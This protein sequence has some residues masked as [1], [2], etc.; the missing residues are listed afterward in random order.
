[1][2]V[3]R[4]ALLALSACSGA[5]A[6]ATPAAEPS[7]TEPSVAV[8]TEASASSPAP[9]T[10][11]TDL[12]PKATSD[13]ARE[14]AAVQTVQLEPVD[15]ALL[16]QLVI[17][18]ARAYRAGRRPLVE[19]HAGWCHIC[20]RVDAALAQPRA[21]AVLEDVVLIRVDT[22]V[23]ADELRAA[24]LRSPTIPAFYPLDR[25]GKPGKHLDGHHW[26]P[27]A[28][29]IAELGQFTDASW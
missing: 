24:G 16:E 6:P 20:R 29:I 14:P 8:R 3:A 18:A 2:K 4:L 25:R 1:M 23:W 22:D 12:E 11:T 10:D 27:N 21:G 15:G 26:K 5:S 28:D 19:M 17:E 13:D 7:A 9:Q